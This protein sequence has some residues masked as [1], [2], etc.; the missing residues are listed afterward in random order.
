[1]FLAECTAGVLQCHLSSE[2]GCNAAASQESL[3]SV[4]IIILEAES[5]AELGMSFPELVHN[6]FKLTVDSYNHKCI[7]LVLLL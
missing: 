5:R 3:K 2:C 7:P 4:F 1:M 6:F